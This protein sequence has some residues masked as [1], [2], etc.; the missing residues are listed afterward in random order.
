MHADGDNHKMDLV[1]VEP[2]Q[3]NAKIGS[4]SRF[5][6][7]AADSIAILFWSYAVLKLFVFHFDV[8]LVSLANADCL[9]LL[10]YKLPILLALIFVAM[11]M[12]KSR[13]I[14]GELATEVLTIHP[15]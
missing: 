8:Y 2:L 14:F 6:W 12:T 9:W 4:R 3:A 5:F 1:V 15:L 10:N 7:I 11:L 13:T